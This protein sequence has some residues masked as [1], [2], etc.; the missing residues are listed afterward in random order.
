MPRTKS[1]GPNIRSIATAAGVSTGTVSRALRNLPGLSEATREEIL[2]IANRLGY[3]TS[4]LRIRPLQRVTLL[5]N[6][7]HMAL[8]HNPFYSLILHGVEEACRHKNLALSYTTIGPSDSIADSIWARHDPDGLIC[9]GYLEDD[10]MKRLA[11]HG[12]PMVIVDSA[13][14]GIESINPENEHGAFLATEHLIQAGYQRIAYLYGSLAHHSIQLRM[15]GYRAA[16]FK[17]GR[18]ADPSLEMGLQLPGDY[19]EAARAATRRLFES[20]NPPDAIF[21]CSDIAAMSA[22]SAL[23]EL[24]LSVPEDVGVIG[25]DDIPSAQEHSPSLSTIR[26]DKSGLGSRAIERLLAIHSGEAPVNLCLPVELVA[27]QSSRKPV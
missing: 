23:K 19:M 26:V 10:L 24:G 4:R 12:R 13:W 18:L 16:L 14:P 7:Q 3:D 11:K 27:R 6:R 25:F 9:A 8:F 2:G 17:H 1:A 5:L 20:P 15:R 22:I 21:A